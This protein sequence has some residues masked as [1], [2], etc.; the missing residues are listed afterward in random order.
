MS[1]VN[2]R[3][4]DHGSRIDKRRI[5]EK[6]ISSVSEIDYAARQSMMTHDNVHA[7][8]EQGIAAWRLILPRKVRLS[9]PEYPPLHEGCQ[10]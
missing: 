5:A 9:I 10:V 7:G 4:Y 8:E 2:T 6:D 1:Y 3:M